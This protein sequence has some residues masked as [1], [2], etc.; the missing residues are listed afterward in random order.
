MMND[1]PWT[2][3]NNEI[4][5]LRAEYARLRNKPKPFETE[6]PVAKYVECERAYAEK[7]RKEEAQ[8]NE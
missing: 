2:E 3:L 6:I 7:L 5:R 1:K 4:G 8:K